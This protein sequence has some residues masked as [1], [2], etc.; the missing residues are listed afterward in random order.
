VRSWWPIP[1]L[2]GAALLFAVADGESGLR[3]WRQLRDDLSAASERIEALRSDV[4]TQQ[5]ASA[6]LEADAFAIERA[7]RERLEYARPSETLV[8]L[9][10]PESLSYRIH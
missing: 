7:I 6:S 2:V 8:R 10:D 4:E 1:A 3:N 9:G 5:E